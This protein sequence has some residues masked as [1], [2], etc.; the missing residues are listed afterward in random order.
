MSCFLCV[1][2]FFFFK[3]YFVQSTS[4]T[5]C[6][7][8]K[9]FFCLS[10]AA[11]RTS[12]LLLFCNGNNI[13]LFAVFIRPSYPV[14]FVCFFPLPVLS[15]SHPPTTPHAIPPQQLICI[16][17]TTPLLFRGLSPPP[18]DFFT[19]S[20][21][22]YYATKKDP[23]F[24]FLKGDHSTASV[25]LNFFSFSL[26]FHPDGWHRTAVSRRCACIK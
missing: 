3:F 2:F 5:K 12:E 19:P 17:H 11:S 14:F 26:C 15:V 25:H 6:R 18:S 16:C 10:E 24:F 8:L 20:F 9:T 23:I 21:V 1:P 13:F 4:Q 7:L 22:I